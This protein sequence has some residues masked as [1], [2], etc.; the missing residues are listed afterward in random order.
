MLPLP[1]RVRVLIESRIERLGEGGRRLVSVAAA[2]G[3]PF[4]F[5]LVERASG[6]GESPAAEGLEELVRHRLLRVGD[7]G[8]DF[9]HDRIREVVYGQLLPPRRALIHRGVAHALEAIHAG[10]LDAHA[11]ALGTHYRD[12]HVWDKAALHL[13]RAGMHAAQRYAHRDAVACYEQALSAVEQLP[14]SRETRELAADAQFNLAHSLYALGDFPRA[15]ACFREA[16]Q[17]GLALEDHD[18]LGEVYAGMAYLLGSEGNFAGA[19]QA[20]LRA[21]TIATSLDDLALMVW[22]SIGLGRVYYARGELGRAIERMRWVAA[23]LAETSRG[24]RFGRSSL[25]PSVACRA[26]LALCLAGTGDFAEALVWGA[27]AVQLADAVGGPHEKVWARYCLS[28]VH[29]ARGEAQHAIGLVDEALPICEGRI[30]LYYPRVVASRGRAL[31]MLGDLAAALPLLERAVAEVEA[32]KLVF[33]QPIIL[34]WAAGAY[35]DAGH[36]AEAERYAATAL[37][38]SRRDGARGDEAWALHSLGEIAGRGR[39]P[40]FEQAIG[41]SLGALHLSQEL[42]MAPLQARCHLSLGTLHRRAG[43][44]EEARAHL[45]RGADM[46]RRLRMWHWLQEAETLLA[47]G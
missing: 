28:R 33:G 41:R 9:S 23:A 4:D 38:L 24:E 22:T 37:A 47:A 10:S 11:L 19:I 6:L 43:D 21:L 34:V 3:R 2:I 12:G 17:L 36:L 16:E 5:A 8:F 27:D 29:L 25:L 7:D 40:D 39:A 46:L 15:M 30:P 18:R 31:T 45:S 42:G 13:T 32:I 20:G 1:E 26:W 35:L 14:D 44:D